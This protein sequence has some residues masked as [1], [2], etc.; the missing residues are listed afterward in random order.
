M[1]VVLNDLLS[2]LALGRPAELDQSEQALRLQMQ[3]EQLAKGAED[4]RLAQ[5]SSLRGMGGSILGG[6]RGTYQSGS[7]GDAADMILRGIQN[8]DAATEQYGRD[9]LARV[10]QE[11]QALAEGG[12]GGA[13][14]AWDNGRIMDYIA[15]TTGGALASIGPQLGAAVLTRGAARPFGSAVANRASTLAGMASGYEMNRDEIAG[16]MLS[17]PAAWERAQQDPRMAQN[18][19]GQGALASSALDIGPGLIASQF[20]K[21]LGV[22]AAKDTMGAVPSVLAG[23]AVEGLTEGVQGIAGRASSD[24][25][26]GADLETALRDN[27]Y[28]SPDDVIGGMLGGGAV[29]GGGQAMVS[30][31]NAAQGLVEDTAVKATEATKGFLNNNPTLKAGIQAAWDAAVASPN[32]TRIMLEDGAA[33]TNVLLKQYGMPEITPESFG[34]ISAMAKAA[35]QAQNMDDF[36]SIISRPDS[37]VN[38]SASEQMGQEYIARQTVNMSPEDRT[39]FMSAPKLASRIGTTLSLARSLAARAVLTEDAES[40]A[41]AKQALNGEVSLIDGSPE[42]RTL[43]TEIRTRALSHLVRAATDSVASGFNA[44]LN[45]LVNVMSNVYDGAVNTGDSILAAGVKPRTMNIQG[46]SNE[47]KMKVANAMVQRLP[48]NSSVMKTAMQ[49]A[50]FVNKVPALLAAYARSENPQAVAAVNDFLDKAYGTG[51]TGAE[52][53]KAVFKIFDAAIG[54]KNSIARPYVDQV[55]GIQSA[56]GDVEKSTAEK[57]MSFLEY[58]MS[59]EARAKLLQTPNAVRGVARVLDNLIAAM[60]KHAANGKDVDLNKASG[61][62]RNLQELFEGGKSGLDSVIEYYNPGFNRTALSEYTQER[63]ESDAV[64]QEKSARDYTTPSDEI[65]YDPNESYRKP[66]EDVRKYILVGVDGNPMFAFHPAGGTQDRYTRK[67]LKAGGNFIRGSEYI[68]TLQAEGVSRQKSAGSKEQE[69]SSDEGYVLKHLKAQILEGINSKLK[70]SSTVYDEVVKRAVSKMSDTAEATGTQALAQMKDNDPKKL[71][72]LADDRAGFFEKSKKAK[73]AINLDMEFLPELLDSPEQLDK[74]RPSDASRALRTAIINKALATDSD[75]KKQTAAQLKNMR[76]VVEATGYADYI[77]G[78]LYGQALKSEGA[79]KDKGGEYTLKDMEA[80][81]KGLLTRYNLIEAALAG[82]EAGD[83]DYASGLRVTVANTNP[84]QAQNIDYATDEDLEEY[85]RFNNSAPGAKFKINFKSGGDRVI[86]ARSIMRSRK[87]SVKATK[88]DRFSHRLLNVLGDILARRDVVGIEI[89]A[90]KKAG[91]KVEYTPLTFTDGA[92]MPLD[93]DENAWLLEPN[94]YTGDPA[95]TFGKLF[96]VD[97]QT[98]E[99][100]EKSEKRKRAREERG[101]YDKVTRKAKAEASRANKKQ[102]DEAEAAVDDH[103][104]DVVFKGESFPIKV[105]TGGKI[106]KLDEADDVNYERATNDAE[107]ENSPERLAG[108]LK[109]ADQLW[110]IVNNLDTGEIR[111]HLQGV[112]DKYPSKEQVLARVRKQL[113][114]SGVATG[115]AK[116]TLSREQVLSAI[117]KSLSRDMSPSEREQAIKNAGVRYDQMR[118]TEKRATT[119][120]ERDRAIKAAAAK[121]D[122]DY[123]TLQY[124]L[125]SEEGFNSAVV[126]AVKNITNTAFGLLGSVDAAYAKQA[127]KE[128]IIR[129]SIGANQEREDMVSNAYYDGKTFNFADFLAADEATSAKRGGKFRKQVKQN[130]AVYQRAMELMQVYG[131]PKRL[132]MYKALQDA[133]GDQSASASASEKTDPGVGATGFG[134]QKRVYKAIPFQVGHPARRFSKDVRLERNAEAFGRT[135][136]PVQKRDPTG[137]INGP[138]RREMKLIKQQGE[139]KDATMVEQTHKFA[140]KIDEGNHAAIGDLSKTGTHARVIQQAR[141]DYASAV[142]ALNAAANAPE[143]TGV[144]GSAVA[145]RAARMKSAAEARTI[146][147]DSV[148]KIT[149]QVKA[150]DVPPGGRKKYTVEDFLSLARAEDAGTGLDEA[151]AASESKMKPSRAPRN[152]AEKDKQKADTV[153]F[154]DTAEV[155]QGPSNALV[156]ALTKMQ[157]LLRRVSVKMGDRPTGILDSLVDVDYSNKQSAYET[158]LAGLKDMPEKQI[159]SELFRKQRLLDSSKREDLRSVLTAEIAAA[160][161]ELAARKDGTTTP[162]Y[163]KPFSKDDY[164]KT[165]LTKL[166]RENVRELL[167]QAPLTQGKGDAAVKIA[168]QKKEAQREY[169]DGLN[170]INDIGS[171]GATDGETVTRAVEMAIKLDRRD[172]LRLITRKLSPAFGLDVEG[173]DDTSVLRS[174]KGREI[175]GDYAEDMADLQQKLRE[176][177]RSLSTTNTPATRGAVRNAETAIERLQAKIDKAVDAGT[178]RLQVST[179]VAGVADKAAGRLKG[180]RQV[181]QT[182]K[183]PAKGLPQKKEAANLP[184]TPW[185]QVEQAIQQAAEAQPAKEATAPIDKTALPAGFVVDA[186]GEVLYGGSTKKQWEKNLAFAEKKLASPDPGAYAATN[187]KQAEEALAAFAALEN[188]AVKKSLAPAGNTVGGFTPDEISNETQELLDQLIALRGD[189]IKLSHAETVTMLGGSGEF[190]IT[191]LG[192]IVRIAIDAMNPSLTIRHEAL[193]DLWATLSKSPKIRRL[194]RRVERYANTPMVMQRVVHS[195]AKMEAEPETAEY[196]AAIKK[197]ATAIHNDPEEGVAYLFQQYTMDPEIQRL[198]QGHFDTPTTLLGKM[199]QPF[200]KAGSAISKFLRDIAGIVTEDEQVDRL[201]AGLWGG[202]FADVDLQ[203]NAFLRE[204]GQTFGDKLENALGPVYIGASRIINSGLDR[205]SDMGIPALTQVVEQIRIPTGDA[206]GGADFVSE[207]Q[208]YQ[209]TFLSMFNK[210]LGSIPKERREDVLHILQSR[211]P[212]TDGHVAL[213]RIVFQNLRDAALQTGVDLGK[214]EDYFPTTWDT[215]TIEED[216]AAFSAL[217][218]KHGDMSAAEAEHVISGMVMNGG[219][220][221]LAEN[222]NHYNY[223]APMGAMRARKLKFINSANAGEFAKFQVKDVDYIVEKYVAELAHR[224]SFAQHFGDTGEKLEKAFE[225]AKEQGATDTELEEAKKAVQGALGVLPTSNMTEGVRT[226][227]AWTITALNT[228]L[229][230]LSL[231]SQ[232]MDPLIVAARSG[233]IRDAGRAYMQALRGLR[234]TIM[235]DKGKNEIEEI[236]DMLGVIETDLANQALGHIVR[237]PQGGLRM[238]NRGFFKLNGMQGFN[239]AMRITATG[240]GMRYIRKA[241]ESN[242]YDDLAELGLRPESIT[243]TA[244]GALDFRTNLAMKKALSRYVESSVVRPDNAH[245]AAWMNDPAFALLAHMRRFTYAFSQTALRRAWTNVGKGD[246][247]PMAFLLAGIPVMIAVDMAKWALTGAGPQTASWGVMDYLKHGVNRTGMLGQ[248]SSYISLVP[249]GGLFAHQIEP[250]PGLDLGNKLLSGDLKGSLDMTLIGHRQLT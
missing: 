61:R 19:L 84:S 227:I 241:V 145:A 13:E 46:M 233:D 82:Y 143:D 102:V 184:G 116:Q 73:D 115:E 28:L 236:A 247:K 71:L 190:K 206:R 215:K 171:R 15:Q 10:Q 240:A 182:L 52:H 112:L 16:N 125:K 119:Q 229:L 120:A 50:D 81:I 140:V 185:A 223:V 49:Q 129:D 228:A 70:T 177:K 42:S 99:E 139:P 107:F 85:E 181:S 200:I 27:A 221:D 248:T 91:D 189:R 5:L 34:E 193:H 230:P 237:T 211:A 101:T 38:H 25:I 226:G 86:S 92:R 138:E 4:A 30:G 169:L 36:L 83:P 105:D 196:A 161:A 14:Q 126:R 37:G 58:A 90:Q 212:S 163:A 29:S 53:K 93:V 9:Q 218:Q 66:E 166:S 64:L 180:I 132:S 162:E 31:I 60:N 155:D 127:G 80:D 191:D 205:V 220:S 47:A 41:L 76:K 78:A 131:D 51:K 124:T 75:T 147:I 6:M 168:T 176:A 165:E 207:R 130:R 103:V 198:V 238:I 144:D 214:V 111:K 153:T 243:R 65:E 149:E 216:R 141:K 72:S 201:L 109:T 250:G 113:D 235:R 106:P 245:Q 69:R 26:A 172:I 134:G 117:R 89:S 74:V 210:V 96:G 178:K 194:K 77:Y 232:F 121:Y 249:G 57:G 7:A 110:T 54:A 167:E 23:S 136:A 44:S 174:K 156:F 202:K 24:R 142:A 95:L 157:P 68:R 67:A 55:K 244:D 152:Q 18:M 22:R 123:N 122:R 43:V 59:D 12:P 148:A 160:N 17:D 62:L 164:I 32:V 158:F 100:I 2:E 192:R 231:F 204:A 195:L 39:K 108:K 186:K 209:N 146:L 225:K 104:F 3:S 11:Q 188:R 213:V 48:S 217:L 118:R 151:Y 208:Y 154:G 175:A 219:G 40:L 133:M 159:K 87:H 56:V 20:G 114:V 33:K 199:V 8:Q 97:P 21:R 137:R 94:P 98:D 173:D 63:D 187:K 246:M 183:G 197:Y 135:G 234:K 35:R 239:N 128:A 170:S 242:N 45:T 179:N 203:D 224:M 150:L 79:K 1:A 88:T 222:E